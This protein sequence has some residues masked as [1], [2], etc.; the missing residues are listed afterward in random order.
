MG[1]GI[2]DD[3]ARRKPNLDIEVGIGA[4]GDQ[5]GSSGRTSMTAHFG[6]GFDNVIGRCERFGQVVQKARMITQVDASVLLQGETGVGKEIFARAIHDSGRHRNAPFIA[7]NCGGLPR[8]LLASELF[9]YVDGAFTG[10]RRAGMVGKIEAAHGGTLFLDEIA[11]MPLELQPYLLRVLEGGEIYPLGSTQPRRVKFR[12]IAA[13]NRDLRAEASAGRFRVDL[14]YRL[15]VTSLH[16][17]ALRERKQDLPELVEH[18]TRDVSR[19]HGVPVKRFA[20]EVMMAFARYSWPGNLRE[21]RNAIEV[22]LLMAEGDVV[23]LS[24]LPDDLS[25]TA[26]E[27]NS[28]GP[29]ELPSGLEEVERDVIGATLRLHQGN[30]ARAAKDLRISRSTLYLKVKKYKLEP[31]LREV[32]FNARYATGTVHERPA[33]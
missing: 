16:I 22:M 29:P 9:G 4:A 3:V 10:A 8:E 7:L 31:T 1:I 17:P 32:R 28:K 21:L 24:T 26:D 2:G 12:L 15:S 27:P 25:A 18:F 20:P 5:L 11:E 23:D 6:N 13:C 19:R 14:F 33:Q 30:L